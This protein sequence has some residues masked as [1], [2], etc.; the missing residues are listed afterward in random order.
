MLYNN[1]FSKNKIYKLFKFFDE[2]DENN[3][4]EKKDNKQEENTLTLFDYNEH[5]KTLIKNILYDNLR[6]HGF[7]TTEI[8]EKI[9]VL[10]TSNFNSVFKYKK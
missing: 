6:Q 10:Q 8:K 7:D 9:N 4:E 3:D 1:L 5:E 2:N